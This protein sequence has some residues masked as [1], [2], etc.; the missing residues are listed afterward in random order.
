MA[1]QTNRW[2]TPALLAHETGR[3]G[4]REHERWLSMPDA[5][6][7]TESKFLPA[8]DDL[9][10]TP[11][12]DLVVSELPQQLGDLGGSRRP[13]IDQPPRPSGAAPMLRRAAAMAW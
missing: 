8:L 13:L 3:L 1:K 11:S 2:T 12:R 7:L 10:S 4:G 9:E 6:A 5:S